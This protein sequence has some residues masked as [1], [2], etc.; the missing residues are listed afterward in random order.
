MGVST[1][2]IICYGISYEEGYEFPW[3][4][5]DIEEWW[6]NDI[7]GFKPVMEVYDDSG[8]WLEGVTEEQINEY[9]EYRRKFKNNHPLPISLVHHCSN[10]YPM[11][12]LAVPSTVI[13]AFRGYPKTINPD[14]FD[15]SNH[16]IQPFIEFCK[17]FD[18]YV[19]DP[20]WYLC[21]YWG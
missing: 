17:E 11:Y 12:I 16:N 13:T 9:F 15:L 20:D 21:S 2:A 3:G 8:E 14:H 4:E 5:E 6:I 19:E 7:K 18:L 1:D 10:D